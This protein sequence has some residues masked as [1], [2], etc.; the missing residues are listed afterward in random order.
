MD[1]IIW[2]L[3][4]YCSEDNQERVQHIIVM[5]LVIITDRCVKTV[6]NCQ[7]YLN[8]YYDEDDFFSEILPLKMYLMFMIMT[9]KTRQFMKH[10]SPSPRI[11]KKEWL[12]VR[13]C[14][15]WCVL[16]KNRIQDC[17]LQ[18]TNGANYEKPVHSFNMPFAHPSNFFIVPKIEI[19][20]ERSQH[21]LFKVEIAVY[22]SIK[23][24]PET[25]FTD[26]MEWKS[27]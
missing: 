27:G 2:E 3:N 18:S 5:N 10:Y 12:L 19:D 7:E 14:E 17:I 16:T 6:E 21:P 20:T 23:S 8:Q 4:R 9:L 13:Y 25:F 1:I 24:K 22:I 15:T 26:G 11:S